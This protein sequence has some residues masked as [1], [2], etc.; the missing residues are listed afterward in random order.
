MIHVKNGIQLP[1][2]PKYSNEL[3]Q[4]LQKLHAAS[5]P[6]RPFFGHELRICWRVVPPL[7]QHSQFFFFNRKT[8][9][10]PKGSRGWTPW[11]R[12]EAP[13]RVLDNP[14][15]ALVLGKGL[16]LLR[17]RSLTQC[18]EGLNCLMAVVLK[19]A[20]WWLTSCVN[21]PEKLTKLTV[22]ILLAKLKSETELRK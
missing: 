2:L 3:R 16:D 5:R 6:A 22:C 9:D 7:K 20:G 12:L 19:G 4:P 8:C 11:T 21:W 17:E 14:L 10:V 1:N 15:L 18:Q 13:I